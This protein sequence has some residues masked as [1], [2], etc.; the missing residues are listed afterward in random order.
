MISKCTLTWWNQLKM[1]I[2]YV[3]IIFLNDLIQ[4]RLNE[5]QTLYIYQNKKKC[6]RI[7]AYKINSSIFSFVMWPI[8][9]FIYCQIS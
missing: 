8:L 1:K 9:D 7:N 6:Y 4:V 5:T 3:T 2:H